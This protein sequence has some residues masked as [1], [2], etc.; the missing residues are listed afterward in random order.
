MVKS[1][2]DNDTGKHTGTHTGTTLQHTLQHALQNASYFLVGSFC[3]NTGLI[4]FELSPYCEV[5]TGK[6]LIFPK[7]TAKDVIATH[8]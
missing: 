7:R 4:F 5:A 2:L 6:L 8:R 1:L 3:K